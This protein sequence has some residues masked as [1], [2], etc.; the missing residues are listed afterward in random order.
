MG[1][2][3]P[4]GTRRERDRR[5]ASFDDTAHH[6]DPGTSMYSTWFLSNNQ[7]RKTKNNLKQRIDQS[8]SEMMAG[9]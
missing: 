2:E 5:M 4:Q 1:V 6:E 8:H 3:P 9:R 7:S